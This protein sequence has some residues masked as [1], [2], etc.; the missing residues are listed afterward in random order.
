M[1]STVSRLV[2]DLNRSI[3]HPQLW[4]AATRSAAGTC[5]RRS[6]NG[7]TSPYREEVAR[8]VRRST[9]RGRRVVHVSSHSFTPVLNGEVRHAD[10]GL[11]YD[12]RRRGGSGAVRP[13]EG[14]AG[15]DRSCSFAYAATIPM[16][17]KATD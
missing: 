4:S 8:R 1:S 5:E 2:I 11:L 6:S 3:G 10:V 12:P 17:A 14:G 15:S 16:P 13:L 7:T 9:A